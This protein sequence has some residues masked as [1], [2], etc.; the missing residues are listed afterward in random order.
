[1]KHGKSTTIFIPLDKVNIL[2]RKVYTVSQI[3]NYLM[4]FICQINHVT[5]NLLI[6]QYFNEIMQNS[7]QL[8]NYM[9]K[10][11]FLYHIYVYEYIYLL[12]EKIT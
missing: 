2:Q 12:G 6:R 4:S 10:D 3:P 1:M 5:S 11:F 7:A 8:V 9:F